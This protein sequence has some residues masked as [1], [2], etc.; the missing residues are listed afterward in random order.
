MISYVFKCDYCFS[1]HAESYNLEY[2]LFLK[3]KIILV[4]FITY[5]NNVSHCIILNIIIYYALW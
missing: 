5:F 2:C 1:V 3:E 4:V